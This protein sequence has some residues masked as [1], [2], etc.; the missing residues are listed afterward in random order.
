ML[1]PPSPLKPEKPECLPQCE[2][3]SR[4]GTG[5][6]RSAAS[7]QCRL[8]DGSIQPPL[9]DTSTPAPKNQEELREAGRQEASPA[10][11]HSIAAPTFVP[12]RLDLVFFHAGTE[13]FNTQQLLRV[14]PLQ[15]LRAQ[16]T[17]NSSVNSSAN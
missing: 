6:R 14:K 1:L 8:T 5:T 13:G 11:R 17:I 16:L 9:H 7:H 2:R 10:P 12:T 4:V 3:W 15:P